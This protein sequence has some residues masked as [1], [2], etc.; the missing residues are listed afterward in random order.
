MSVTFSSIR[1]QARAVESLRRELLSG[2]LHHAHLFSGPDGVGK[3][4]VATALFAALNCERLDGVTLADACGACP[5]CK[6][7]AAN[8]HPD[9]VQLAPD[10]RFIKIE[11]VREVLAETRY[12]PF[13][14]RAR[15]VL[16]DQADALK[17]EA[18]NAL[19]K[20]LEEPGEGTFFVLVSANPSG[21]LETIRS[22]S[23]PLR[24]APLS[25]EDVAA[26]L[27]A[28]G[29][30][31]ERAVIAGAACAGSLA[32][33]RNVLESQSFLLRTERAARF[34]AALEGGDGDA[35]MLAE[36]LAKTRDEMPQALGFFLEFFRDAAM[37]RAGGSI[38]RAVHRD[39]IEYA[40]RAGQRTDVERLARAASRAVE[41]QRQ[42][43]GNVHPLLAAEGFVLD[44]VALLRT[45]SRPVRRASVT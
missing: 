39:L 6:R 20:T 19:L 35:L 3:R 31:Q 40:R 23:V 25:A 1:G 29:V 44:A 34:V 28:E 26:L 7:L 13:V 24:F 2:R 12:R 16:F 15:V 38:Q 33:A 37:L 43:L 22:R 41:A 45:P 11:Q 36:E 42:L 8:Q 27:V 14:G 4:R 5:Q 21:V 10:G 9:F 32:A 17:D 30:E 18:A